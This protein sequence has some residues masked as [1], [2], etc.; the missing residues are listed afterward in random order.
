MKL[1]VTSDW[2]LDAVTAGLERFGDIDRAARAAVQK[3]LEIEAD[4]F[5]FLGDLCDPDTTRSHRAIAYAIA[6]ERLMREKGLESWWLTGN[7]DVIEDGT[8]TSTL[9]P[10]KAAGAKVFDS[11]AHFGQE[12]GGVQVIVL[13]FTPRSH[14]YSPEDYVRSCVDHGTRRMLVLGH[15]N[16]EGIGPGSETTDLPR[17]RDVFLPLTAIRER[18]PGAVVLNGHYHRGQ[19][20]NGVFVPGSL[21]RLTFG[22]EDNLPGYLIVEV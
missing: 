18:W 5:V 8:G 13:P 2:H 17:G 15:L 19:E 6:V 11:P 1:L 7:H 16:I 14:A 3:A 9:T 22:E 4:R 10:L 12:G 21:A 20:F